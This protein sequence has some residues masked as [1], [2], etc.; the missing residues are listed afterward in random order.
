M[1]LLFL[2]TS[3]NPAPDGYYLV[4]LNVRD[5]YYHRPT[6]DCHCWKDYPVEVYGGRD[7]EPGKEGG[8]WLAASKTGKVGVLLNILQKP[9]KN[10]KG[11]GYLV[12]DYVTSQKDAAS[13]LKDVQKTGKDYNGFTLVTVEMKSSVGL[14]TA[15]LNNVSDE[16]PQH[17]PPGN[18]I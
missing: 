13:Y 2:S 10:K 3:E 6:L 17:I 4:L 14:S 9:D 7:N 16:S 11:R 1:C 18:V 8:T 5:E 12:V 15:F